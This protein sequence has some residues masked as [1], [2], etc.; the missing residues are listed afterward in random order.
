MKVKLLL[1][2]MAYA[3]FSSTQASELPATGTDYYSLQ[4]ASGKDAQALEKLYRR[5]AELP[6]VRVER[7]GALYVLRAGFWADQRAARLAVSNARVDA[8]FIRVAAFR[9]EAIVQRN[10][11]DDEALAAAPVAP[12]APA[13]TRPTPPPTGALTQPVALRKVPG[14]ATDTE[15]LLPFNQEDFVLAYDVLLGSGDLARAFQV[16]RQAVQQ[17]PQD[18]TWRRKLAQVA[19]WTQ[20]PLV[21]AEQWRALFQQGDHSQETV[22]AVI[23]LAL[24]LDDP[25]IALQAWAVRA[26]QTTLTAAQW[27]DIFELYESA[28]E[29]AKGSRFFEAQF[30]Q[31]KIPL[32]LEYAARLAEHAGDDERAGA[33]FTQRAQLDPFS[34][35][36][37]LRAVVS[38][39]RRDHMREAL[40][41][42]QTHEDK[43]PADASEFWRLLSQVA[44]ELRDY[45]AAQGAYQRFAQTPQATTADWSRLVFLVRQKHP[46]QAAGLAL[47]AYRRFGALDQLVLG[48]GLYAEMGDFQA[49]ARVFKSLDAEALAAAEQEVRFLLIRAQYEQRQKKPDLAWVDLRR[50][51]QK[52]PDE[53][54]VVLASLWFLIDEARADDLAL[55][56]RHYA[57]RAVNDPAY[58]LAYAAGNQ[59]LDRHREAVTWYGK[60]IRRHPEDPL[61]LLNYADALERSQR[62]GMAERVRRHAWLT[63]KQKYPH[64][65][66]LQN[67]G[68]NPDLLSL[69]RL[70]I[71]NQPGDPG[72]Q[73]VR[74]LAQQMR[75]LPT[76]PADDGQTMA[77]VLG[78]AIAKEQFANAR[79]WMWLRYARQSQTAPPLWG[80]SQVALQ[81]GETQTMDRLLTRNSQGLPIYNRYDTAYALGH[82]PQALDIAFKGMTQQDGD[83]P[84]H[85]RFRQHAPLH[86]N[87]IQ[88]KA[89][90]DDL[91]SLEQQNVRLGSVVSQGLQWEARLVP[92]PK[93]HV[94]L[95]WSRMGQSSDDASDATTANPI[96]TVAAPTSDRLNSVE[97]RWLGE[98]GESSLTLFRRNELQGYNGLRLSQT[99]QWGSRINLEAGLDYR[100]DSTL[101]LPLQVFGYE[102]GLHASLNYTLGKREYLRIAPRVTRYYTQFGDYLGS[103]RI[104]ELE[105]GYR[106]RTE[107]P[108]WRVRTF[109]TYQR[110]SHEGG[111]GDAFKAT[112]SPSVQTA[113]DNGSFDPVA[114][115][116][117]E[118]NTTWGACVSMGENLAGQNLQTVYSRAWRPFVDFCLS[119][120]TAGSEGYTGILGMAG[121]LTGEDHLSVQLQNSEGYVSGGGMT[122][123]L[124]IRYRHYY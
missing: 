68:K 42:M 110:A 115:L 80:D 94:I 113:I 2:C 6:F 70:A 33:L 118:G 85:D 60:E 14:V 10:W 15:V 36:A 21:A 74:Q 37:V 51:L 108:D 19:E 89:V 116:I 61:V 57:S 71:L 99:L 46:A 120:N 22:L 7:R 73:L 102:T 63:L 12:L 24:L 67:L 109:A 20:H 75:G 90:S 32:L 44:W 103:G 35:D 100:A 86:A 104:L 54:E 114:F 111:V 56:L 11:R 96:N 45:E 124:A 13:P 41:L 28:V 119:H 8:P 84:L 1:A 105:A 76:D 81:L 5:Y 78:W 97:A 88:L 59:V 121:S 47:D 48:L 43:V 3:G 107:Y 52:S 65:E 98:R 23:R 27:E 29:P 122:R 53:T 49:Q 72:L 17:A 18:S 9:P 77:L 40:S 93:L 16:A 25:S 55:A 31:K 66:N 101:S 30:R 112:L 34:M 91:G 123:S 26:K 4:I 83:E 62:E 69:V 50:A 117:P 87:Y 38:L 39:I 82:V 79:A 106:I 64:P 95:G 92:H 58:W